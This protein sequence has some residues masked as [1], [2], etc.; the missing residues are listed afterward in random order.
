[1]E[2]QNI[3]ILIPTHFDEYKLPLRNLNK[4]SSYASK[5]K[6]KQTRIQTESLVSLQ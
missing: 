2:R 4:I 5:T 3:S 6:T 1:M